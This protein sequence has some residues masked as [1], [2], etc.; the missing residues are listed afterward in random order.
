M[1]NPE[2]FR[3]SL[4]EMCGPCVICPKC[5]MNTCSGGY[6]EMDGQKCDVCPQAYAL[7]EAAHN[8]GTVPCFHT[9][10]APNHLLPESQLF[11]RVPDEF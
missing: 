6:G 7:A 10:K 4:C 9:C 11:G 3:W 8:N 1:L 2:E 5:G